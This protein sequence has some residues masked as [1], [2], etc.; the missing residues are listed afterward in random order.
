V[1][2]GRD[3]RRGQRAPAW[4]LLAALAALTASGGCAE[5]LGAGA[6]A[7]PAHDA[8]G[9]GGGGA[10]AVEREELGGG[11]LR[12]VVR[13]TDKA[14]A[15]FVDLDDGRATPG[16]AGAAW[17]LAIK[18]FQIATNGGISG[19]GGAQVAW[20]DGVGFEAAGPAPDAGW[21]ADAADGDDADSDAD[22]AFLQ[23][24]AWYVYDPATHQLSPRPRVYFVR[25]GDG[26]AWRIAVEGYYDAVGTA[27]VVTLRVRRLADGAPTGDG[28]AGEDAGALDAAGDGGG[29]TGGDAAGD[30]APTWPDAIAWAAGQSGAW[31]AYRLAD[32]AAVAVADLASSSGWDV[33]SSGLAFRTNSGTS[34]P[35]LGGAKLAGAGFDA[36]EKT[37]TTGFRV[38][39]QI[40]L[41]GPPGSG[42][43]SGNPVLTSWWDYDPATHQV[44][45]KPTASWI[46]R[47]AAGGYAKV[48]L[49]G[50]AGQQLW[51]RIGAVPHEAAVHQID[52]DAS[53]TAWT[54]V[55]LRDA[56]VVTVEGDAAQDQRWDLALQGVTM[57]TNGGTSGAGQ[58]AAQALDAADLATVT[59]LPSAGWVAD[60]EQPVAGPPGS[61][62]VSANAALG[63]WYDY[64]PVAHAVSPKAV[65][66][67]VR[68]A[69]GS[70]AAVQVKAYAKGLVTLAVRYAGPGATAL[71]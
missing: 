58:G 69:D 22:L 46:V 28:G 51:V 37:D 35:G 50:A 14:A 41:P 8:L 47:G 57:R 70:L 39:E 21:V 30:A 63:A 18:R 56:E 16:P 11:A 44:S 2:G 10:G 24:G 54:Y 19:G 68:C 15:V 36:V 13:A 20:L 4:W 9:D 17:E 49:V 29:T 48:Q 7:S 1:G 71:P 33:A 67:A 12:L 31:L 64:D 42:S 27:G 52:V 43:A 62:T 61:G 55:S 38:D 53:K 6:G 66:F 23:G 34:G 5:D 40:A 59:A 25:M 32:G 45:V 65:V 60:S 3:P 26:R